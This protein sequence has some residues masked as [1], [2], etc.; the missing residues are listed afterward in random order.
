VLQFGPHPNRLFK[1]II[2]KFALQFLDAPLK[3]KPSKE[4]EDDAVLLLLTPTEESENSGTC[5]YIVM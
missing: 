2:A 3:R 4:A 1:K 5:E